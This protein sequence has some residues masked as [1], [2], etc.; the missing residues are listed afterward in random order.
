M[1]HGAVAPLRIWY[2]FGLAIVRAMQKPRTRTRFIQPP[3]R[4][5]TLV[6]LMVAIVILAVL[7]MLAVS[8]WSAFANAMRLSALTNDFL[9]QLHLARSEA[10]KRNSRVALCTSSDGESCAAQ[11]GWDQGWIVFHDANNNSLRE[12][13]ETIVYR[14]TAMP[15]GFHIS[16]NKNVS[17]YVSFGAEGETQLVSGAFQAGTVTV[18]KASATGTEAREIV[19][20]SVGRPRIRK[21]TVAACM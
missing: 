15:P 17:R 20:N 18:C 2:Y 19:I 13:Q 14:F 10:I 12:T 11:G 3:P 1:S 9:S 8:A 6:E 4:G 5:F 16:G 21:T 7:T